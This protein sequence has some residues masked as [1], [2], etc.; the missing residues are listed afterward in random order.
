MIR[1]LLALALAV[2]ALSAS[3]QSRISPFPLPPP[4][5][6]N[7]A[8]LAAAFAQSMEGIEVLQSAAAGQGPGAAIARANLQQIAAAA[9]R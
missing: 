7:D 6:S 3:A 1:P 4:P 5:P 2:S 9:S 8:V